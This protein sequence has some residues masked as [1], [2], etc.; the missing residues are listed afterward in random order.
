MPSRI[1]QATITANETTDLPNGGHA[2][3]GTIISDTGAVSG[4]VVTAATLKLAQVKCYTTTAYLAVRYGGSSGDVVA[5]TGALDGNSSDHTVTMELSSLSPGL[6]AD[7]S[8]IALSVVGTAGSGNKINFRP[9]C[10]ITLTIDYEVITACEPPETVTVDAVNVAPGTKVNLRWSGASAGTSNPIIGYE[11]YRAT[12]DMGTYELLSTM[13]TTDTAGSVTVTAPTTNGTAYFYKIRTIGSRSG[14]EGALSEASAT[15]ACN[16]AAVGAP[17]ALRID[18]TNVAPGAKAT[19]SW[20]GATAGENNAITGYKIYQATAATGEYKLLSTVTTA[21]T[22][23]SATVTAP[24]ESGA[25]HYYKVQTLGA[26]AGN[27]SELSD[28]Y[29]ALTCTYSS[30]SAPTRVQIGGASSVYSPPGEPLTLNWSGAADGAN[31][32][33][34]GYKVYQGGVEYRTDL[35]ADVTSCSVPAHDAAGCSY[36]YTVAAIGTYSNS[37]Q[38]TPVWVY[39][40]TDPTAPTAV[41]VANSKPA[42]NSRTTL[43][44]SG[45][46]P[47]GYNDIAGYRVY[48]STAV[49]GEYALIASVAA[50]ALSC[51]V[52][53][54]NREG[55]VYYFR[56]VTVGAYS[57]SAKSTAYAAVT[58][59]E[60]TSAEGNETTVIVT[61]RRREKR[62]IIFGDYDTAIDGG[63]TLTGWSFPEPATQ[64]RFVSVPLRLDGP[65]DQSTTLTDGDPRF[66]SRSLTATFE[67][68]EGTRLEREDIISDM[69]NRLHGHRVRII[70]PD[71]PA[72]YAEGRLAVAKNYNDMAHAAVTV[73][74]TCAPW[75]YSTTET[76]VELLASDVVQMAVLS[77]SGRRVAVPEITLTGFDAHVDLLCEGRSWTLTEGTHRLPGLVLRNGNTLISYSGVGTLA[78]RYREAIL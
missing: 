53:A 44:W 40:Y 1:I 45:A 28:T 42:A 7:V 61:P 63:W 73:K 69:L 74:A 18:T 2:L 43:S 13:A 77:N 24:S 16:F 52:N 11:I 56:V 68:S 6:L 58:A 66:G 39:S 31:N 60:D 3:F 17:T 35:G 47:G 33:I 46:K 32:P 34:T 71:D 64:E 70:L 76:Q 20:S 15:L 12:S 72:H 21:E 30:P 25:E 38:S 54:P 50:T 14:Y 10:T 49:N 65:L 19:L 4:A 62:K 67:C 51:P 48:R 9:G 36:K 29:A 55:G 27:D 37:S 23:G 8:T 57:L 41:S 59:G 22:F 78:L 75:R 26:L 5:I